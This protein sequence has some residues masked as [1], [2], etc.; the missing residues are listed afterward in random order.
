MTELNGDTVISAISTKLHSSFSPAPKI[1][2]EQVEQGLVKPC[3]FVSCINQ[4]Q[5][6]IAPNWYKRVASME[7]RYHPTE[8]TN[9]FAQCRA[10]GEKLLEVLDS[11]DLPNTLINYSTLPCWGRNLEYNIRDEVLIFYVT[12]EFKVKKVV[13]PDT[14]M[15]SLDFNL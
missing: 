13:V 7:V 6:R 1:Y 11:V 15:N 5:E 2:K 10:V 4:S 12:Y 14:P 3:F 9:K 8:G